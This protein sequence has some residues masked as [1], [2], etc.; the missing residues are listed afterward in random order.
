MRIKIKSI[1]ALQTY[2]LRH[3]LLREGHPIESC[4][5]EKDL[6]P[7][8]IHLGAYFMGQLVGVLSAMPS[9]L[10]DRKK[11]NGIQLRAIAVKPSF[12]RKGI[13]TRLIHEV[14]HLLK[15]NLKPDYIWLNA[16]IDAI[17]LYLKNGFSKTGGLFEIEPIGTH[18]RFIKVL[19][20]ES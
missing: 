14:I 3:P 7:N 18:Q 15:S 13:A 6:D 20:Y 10:E 11:Q 8:S 12:Q 9:R 4:H 1:Q 2:E 16:R 17:P 19:N 5:L